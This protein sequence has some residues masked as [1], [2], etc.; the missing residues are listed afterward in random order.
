MSTPQNRM[1]VPLNS[2]AVPLSGTP[3]PIRGFEHLDRS[4][5]AVPYIRVIQPTSTQAE[6]MDGG[7]ARPGTFYNTALRTASEEL[8]FSI[9]SVHKMD[10]TWEEGEEEAQRVYMI[11]GTDERYEPLVL[12]VAGTSIFGLKQLITSIS[13]SGVDAAWTWKVRAVT[14]K[15]EGK[16]GKWYVIKF[17]LRDRNGD[18]NADLL[19]SMATLYSPQ[20]ALPDVEIIDGE[21]IEE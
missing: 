13:R 5:E 16:M 19:E 2:T 6:L 12:K 3:L 7:D 17:Y 1:M 11:L 15:R 8:L 20:M 10:I 4:D 21:V 18:G 9:L 14:E